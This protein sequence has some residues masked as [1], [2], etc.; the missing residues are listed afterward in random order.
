MSVRKSIASRKGLAI[1]TAGFFALSSLSLSPIAL[2]QEE[3]GQTATANG[4][5]GHR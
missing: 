5:G 4:G 3:T 2:A 1:A